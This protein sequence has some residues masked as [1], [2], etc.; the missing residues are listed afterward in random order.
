MT[1]AVAT[2]LQGHHVTQLRG[3]QH[4]TLA[5][6]Q[7]CVLF[8]LLVQLIWHCHKYVHHQLT[9]P[10]QPQRGLCVTA[11]TV[12]ANMTALCNHQAC[13]QGLSDAGKAPKSCGCLWLIMSPLCPHVFLPP[14]C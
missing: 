10:W 9:A 12:R 1:P 2:S 3:G 14:T 8:A 5:L 7:V 13:R 6:T 11:H 4:H